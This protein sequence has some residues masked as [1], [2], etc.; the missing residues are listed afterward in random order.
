[1]TRLVVLML[2]FALSIQAV[3]VQAQGPIA[4]SARAALAQSTGQ[5][6]SGKVGM[7][8]AG[9]ALMGT[10]A[11]LSI[12]ANTALR[13][14]ECIFSANFFVCE[15]STPKGIWATGIAMAAAGGILTT[16]GASKSIVVSP[17]RVTYRLRF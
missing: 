16:I 7:F 8:W 17:T 6:S 2:V 9:I 12:L 3:A 5:S 14:E 4:Q 11:T 15:E 13:K 1:M 10:G